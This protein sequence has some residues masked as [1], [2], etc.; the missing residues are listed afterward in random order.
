MQ[1]L[2]EA[3]CEYL[4]NQVEGV[5][6]EKSEVTEIEDGMEKFGIKPFFIEKGLYVVHYVLS[7]CDCIMIRP[8]SNSLHLLPNCCWSC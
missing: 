7:L 6:K 8:S 2:R 3:C 1:K 4:M 5:G